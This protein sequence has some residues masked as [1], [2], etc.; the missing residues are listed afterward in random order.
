MINTT[1][2]LIESEISDELSTKVFI[3][4]DRQWI[5]TIKVIY[6]EYNFGKYKVII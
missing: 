5:I 6:L 1:G 3:Y 4:F 2:K